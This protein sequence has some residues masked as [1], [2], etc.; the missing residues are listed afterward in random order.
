MRHIATPH[1]GFV[2]VEHWDAGLSHMIEVVRTNDSAVL[3]VY[4]EVNERVLLV[5]Q[6]RAPMIRED[7]PAGIIEELVAG[8]FDKSVGPMG[9]AIIEAMEEAGI[10]LREE[11]VE[12][13]NS[14]IPMA[15]SAGVITER[16]YGMLAIIRP[17]QITEGDDGYGVD[18]GEEISRV[19]YSVQDFIDRVHSCWRVWG[20]AQY[21]ARRRLEQQLEALRTS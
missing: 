2:Q 15:V 11:D 5:R 12:I 21:I 1:A 14:G 16:S 8:R 13:I 6:Q 19:W 3:C 7:N 17:Q 20:F 10:S 18:E 9:L 4:D